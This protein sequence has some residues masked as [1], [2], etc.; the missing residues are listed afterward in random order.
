MAVP[1]NK[2]IIWL[3]FNPDYL[4]WLICLCYDTEFCFVVQAD[5]ELVLSA[6]PADDPERIPSFN[7]ETSF[8]NDQCV[9]TQLFSRLELLYIN[10]S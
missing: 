8:S 9:Q 6:S 3:K 7:N 5:I 2:D 10:S 4:Y 1:L